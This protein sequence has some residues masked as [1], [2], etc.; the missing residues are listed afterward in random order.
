MMKIEVVERIWHTSTLNDEEEKKIKE[1]V[2]SNPEKF[3]YVSTKES[4][5]Q[6]AY[7]LY[8]RGEIN[9]YRDSV[10]SDVETEELKWSEYEE[11]TPDEIL[12]N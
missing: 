11:K 8:G 6:A 10:E 4:V 9:L 5:L 7:E 2:K 12:G 3:E 1:Y